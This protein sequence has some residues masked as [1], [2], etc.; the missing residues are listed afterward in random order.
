MGIILSGLLACD[1]RYKKSED[2]A[3]DRGLS[4]LPHI[5]KI[6]LKDWYGRNLA[7]ID[8]NKGTKLVGKSILEKWYVVLCTSM[9][10]LN[11]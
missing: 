4:L 3:E 1:Q 2:Y 6:S 9:S 5:K 8:K 10:L 7:F 11:Y